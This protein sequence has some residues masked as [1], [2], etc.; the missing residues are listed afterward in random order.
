MSHLTAYTTLPAVTKLKT[1]ALNAQ[2]R[3]KHVVSQVH[4]DKRI[5]CDDDIIYGYSVAACHSAIVRSGCRKSCACA[6]CFPGLENGGLGG[7]DLKITDLKITD[8]T[9]SNVSQDL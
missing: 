4:H 3:C 9:R 1:T 6:V 2:G 7:V 5:K 8:L